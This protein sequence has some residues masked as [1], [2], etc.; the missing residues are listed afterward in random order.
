MSQILQHIQPYKENRGKW[1]RIGCR[2]WAPPEKKYSRIQKRFPC[3]SARFAWAVE[4]SPKL[5][6]CLNHC[7]IQPQRVSWYHRHRFSF[8][9]IK[10]CQRRGVSLLYKIQLFLLLF[11]QDIT[12]L[13]LFFTSE[14]TILF[15]SAFSC[16]PFL[17]FPPQ[18]PMVKSWSS[19]LFT[20]MS[21]WDVMFLSFPKMTLSAN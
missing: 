8:S 20:W 15:V 5:F 6:F 18:R 2:H 3:T 19:R 7:Q 11:V 17:L 4:K 21:Q 14:I 12:C 13:S 10:T 9:S 1:T 16:P